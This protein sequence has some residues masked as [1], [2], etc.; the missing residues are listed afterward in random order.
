MRRSKKPA[1]CQRLCFLP[2]GCL[3]SPGDRASV[4]WQANVA[5]ISGMESLF[6]ARCR[7]HGLEAGAPSALR[8]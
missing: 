3:P 4:R 7:K 2:F 1:K 8:R 6:T 5:V